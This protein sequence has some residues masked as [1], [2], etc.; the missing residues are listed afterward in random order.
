MAY[1]TKS[2][3]KRP[4]DKKGG[5]SQH[6]TKK[7]SKTTSNNSSSGSGGSNHRDLKQ[8]RHS[9]RKHA[10]IVKD[11]KE[12][13]NKLRLKSITS[14]ER[15]ELMDQLIP[16]I[17]GKAREIALQHDASRVVQAAIQ[18]GTESERRDV[19]QELCEQP[20]TF[21]EL[22][23]SQYAHFVVLKVVK[24][25]HN[26]EACVKLIFKALRGNVAK[27]AGHAVA[28]SVIESIFTTLTPKQT[29][30]LKQEFYGPQFA[31]FAS[32]TVQQQ[33]SV[34][35]TLQSNLHAAPDAKEK[36]LEFVQN[37]VNKGME[38]SHYGYTFFQEILCEYVTTTADVNS[39][40]IRTMAAS[41]ADNVIHL[42]STRAGTRV[43]ATFIAYGTA[44]DRKRIM[45]SLKG[46]TRSALM[47]HDAYLAILRLVQLT[48][49][50]VSVQKNLLNELL[51]S[52]G[53]GEEAS[54]VSS[55]L[56]IALSDSASKLFLMLLVEDEEARDKY[57][58]PYER[59]VLAPNPTVEENGKQVPTSK[60][61]MLIR[62]KELLKDLREPLIELCK[63][64][65][66]QLLRSLPGSLVLREV[67]EAFGSG[68]VVASILDVCKQAL[69]DSSEEDG[70]GHLPLFE[71][72]N[73]QLTLKHLML[74]DESRKSNDKRFAPKFLSTFESNLMDICRS[75]RGA[76]VVEALCKERST[77]DQAKKQINKKELQQRVKQH[78]GPN[79]GFKALLSTL[80]GN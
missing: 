14:K 58:D 3:A 69:E 50:T 80:D 62:R 35:P 15:R 26:D 40:E 59:T 54:G 43:A 25:C 7:K 41:A 71:D 55:L 47:H 11:A 75:S 44:K 48:D 18:F 60:K 70:R 6:P 42:L 64:H 56:D 51:T 29:A 45:K 65:T 37:L 57:F 74:A 38:K 1:D 49:D 13:W 36:T 78:K 63:N 77:R 9:Q 67:H 21:I 17:R 32:D 12:I 20:G 72:L 73:A 39:K 31:L 68:A 52:T 33:D 66:E 76:F 8:Q 79:A 16:L 34:A 4:A 28:S 5:S 53:G 61:D 22:C 30:V 2:P 24:Y 23:K 19:L 46:Y 27:L 10:D